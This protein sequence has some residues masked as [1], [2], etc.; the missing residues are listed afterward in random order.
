MNELDN[1]LLYKLSK[2]IGVN[3][4]NCTYRR[5]YQEQF[6]YDFVIVVDNNFINFCKVLDCNRERY[7]V[8]DQLN[9]WFKQVGSDH[10]TPSTAGFITHGNEDW[11]Y[12]IIPIGNT[13]FVTD[14]KMNAADLQHLWQITDQ[15]NQQVSQFTSEFNSNSFFKKY[16]YD[17]MTKTYKTLGTCY[18]EGELYLNFVD[19]EKT[20]ELSRFNDGKLSGLQ[21]FLG[22]PPIHGRVTSALY[23]TF[24]DTEVEIRK[25]ILLL[26][27]VDCKPIVDNILHQ[28]DE[29]PE[30][31]YLSPYELKLHFQKIRNLL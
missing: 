9:N 11:F 8:L 22:A 5:I 25:K 1:I 16:S 6:F 15:L 21:A 18:L 31:Y 2:Y 12:E 13:N 3:L 19:F 7:Q 4:S 14:K 23:S 27:D 28:I 17:E 20:F 30:F 29:Y 10:F 26:E 24:F